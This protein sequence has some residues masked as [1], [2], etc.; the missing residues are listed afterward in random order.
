MTGKELQAARLT[1]TLS[2]TKMADAIGLH[3][4]SYSRNERREDVDPR[5]AIPALLVIAAWHAHQR[6]K[7]APEFGQRLPDLV[8][9]LS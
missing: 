9:L 5:V 1:T 4:N 3:W 2:Q 8:E 7:L 6:G